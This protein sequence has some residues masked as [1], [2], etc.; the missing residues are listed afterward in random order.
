MCSI[1]PSAVIKCTRDTCTSERYIGVHLFIQEI[2][3][4]K[5]LTCRRIINCE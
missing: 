4:H 3:D 1:I 2:I 5:I